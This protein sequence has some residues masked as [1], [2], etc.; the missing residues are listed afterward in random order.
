MICVTSAQYQLDVLMNWQDYCDKINYL[1]LES[2]SRQ[3]N[4]VLLSE[5]A[6]CEIAC[7]QY[8]TDLKLYQRIQP[9]VPD[10]LDFY[11]TLS[12]KHQLYIQPGTIP[13][14]VAP[15]L[16]VNRAFFFSPSGEYG[17][18]DKLQLTIYERLTKVM[19]SG[20]EQTVFETPLGKVGIAICYDAEFPELMRSLALAGAKLILIPSYTNS[21]AGAARVFY[22]ARAR[23]IENQCYVATSAVVGP[24]M[25]TQEID[26]C[27][28]VTAILGPA[29]KQFPD[30]GILAQTETEGTT[31]LTANLDFNKIDWVRKHG[32]VRNFMDTHSISS[33]IIN[34]LSL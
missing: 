27:Q 33:P 2:K 25:L 19:V 32:S 9:A 29:D 26:H 12:K 20:K 16:F 15:N 24:M 31:L 1:V 8:D 28:G 21:A 18:Q 23:A 4:L 13:I 7:G 3:T 6:G 22:C 17:F 30:D 34:V 11:S 5:Y 14:E 10:Y